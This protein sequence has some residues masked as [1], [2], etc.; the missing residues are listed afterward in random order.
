MV[1]PTGVDGS[2]EADCNGGIVICD[3]GRSSSAGSSRARGATPMLRR[4]LEVAILWPLRQYAQ[5][6][7]EVH[8]RID[9]VQPAGRDDDEGW[10][11]ATEVEILLAETEVSTTRTKN[12]S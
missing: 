9:T 12:G 11:F 10:W 7:V 4:K 1:Q 5:D 8:E 6:L 2:D 3:S